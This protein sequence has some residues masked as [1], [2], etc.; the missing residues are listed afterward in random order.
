MA[1]TDATRFRAIGDALWT[2]DWNPL[3][4][5]I[6]GVNERTIRRW[7]ASE[8]GVPSGVWQELAKAAAARASDIAAARTAIATLCHA[9]AE[10]VPTNEPDPDPPTNAPA[11]STSTS[12]RRP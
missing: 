3:A 2:R 1:E 7:L 10:G 6:L 5:E 12:T 9:A 4:A 11:A 8:S